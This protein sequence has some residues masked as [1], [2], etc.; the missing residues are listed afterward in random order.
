LIVYHPNKIYH[1]YDPKK[2]SE[3]S[4]YENK[5]V[6]N[7]LGEIMDKID[8]MDDRYTQKYVREEPLDKEILN[9]NEW[10]AIKP[11]TN[12]NNNIT[13]YPSN[14]NNNTNINNNNYYEEEVINYVDLDHNYTPDA[15]MNNSMSTTVRNI[16]ED[17]DIYPQ[18]PYEIEK[19]VE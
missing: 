17:Y 16:P 19:E 9:K 3:P 13:N 8:K 2:W 10:E 11:N 12:G 1:N 18:D 7:N 15:N 6:N 5:K 4:Y 14:K